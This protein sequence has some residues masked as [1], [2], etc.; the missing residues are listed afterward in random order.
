MVQN[1]Q[2]YSAWGLPD[3]SMLRMTKAPELWGTGKGID[4][5]HHTYTLS[6]DGWPVPV[7][8]LLL[9]GMIMFVAGGMH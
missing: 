7:F 3:L 2:S 6:D 4:A 8:F 1:F 9:A 5:I